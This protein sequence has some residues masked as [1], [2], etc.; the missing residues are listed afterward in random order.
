MQLA[1]DT[2]V[3]VSGMLSA[4]GPPGQILNW[5]LQGTLSPVIC[6]SILAEYRDVCLREKIGIPSGK[7]NIILNWMSG[8]SV[9]YQP[10]PW[11]CDLPDPDDGVF[12]ALAK[13][14]DVPMVTGNLRHYP[15]DIRDGVMVMNPL[16]FVELLRK[17]EA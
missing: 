10:L 5:V 13:A 4:S 15:D 14:F 7:S 11:P 9:G 12:L 8:Y 17:L 6:P 1:L 2:N 16:E 3:L